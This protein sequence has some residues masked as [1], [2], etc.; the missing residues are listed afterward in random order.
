VNGS[1]DAA[2]II[3]RI[4]L[5][6]LEKAGIRN[7]N[8]KSVLTRIYRLGL[9]QWDVEVAIVRKGLDYD[10]GI[11][12]IDVTKGEVVNV[13]PSRNKQTECVVPDIWLT[14]RVKEILNREKA[15]ID[16]SEPIL[17]ELQQLSNQL[18]FEDHIYIV[19]KFLPY[20]YLLIAVKSII[21]TADWW[22]RIVT[23]TFY[24]SAL[25][26]FEELWVSLKNKREK[27]FTIEKQLLSRIS[28]AIAAY[29]GRAEVSTEDVDRAFTLYD[30][31]LYEL[32][33]C[34]DPAKKHRFTDSSKLKGDS[35]EIKIFDHWGPASEPCEEKAKHLVLNILTFTRTLF[36]LDRMHRLN[37]EL[38]KARKRGDHATVKK[39]LMEYFE[40]WRLK[41]DEEE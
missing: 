26:R 25:K 22:N 33:N 15:F 3:R 7:P 17:Q 38:K 18:E 28:R 29:E 37:E 34:Y 4:V 21:E 39:L 30:A 23:F 6:S 8:P 31:I 16:E 11:W 27:I 9:T 41:E 13:Y 20:N 12:R 1:S 35:T 40:A 19:H 10:L 32:Y 36:T 5:I 14:K 24:P 2:E